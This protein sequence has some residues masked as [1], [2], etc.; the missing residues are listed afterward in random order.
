MYI[1]HVGAALAGK[2]VRRS[3]GLLILLVA[4]YVPDWVDAG[5]CL[6]GSFR[7]TEML[8][9][10]IPAVA[11][12]AL[13][14]FAAYGLFAGDWKGA[15][16]VGAVFISHMLL[17]WITGSKPSWASGPTIGLNLYASPALDFVAEGLV[18]AIGCLLYAPTLPPRRRPWTDISLMLGALL[19][20]QLAI[21]LAHFFLPSVPKC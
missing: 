8:S 21:D 15:A 9:H 16:L 1:G 19:I 10:S 20:M 17:D 18:I 2:R 6:A 13:A 11:L 5:L 4:T 12:F 3:M 7:S 14:G